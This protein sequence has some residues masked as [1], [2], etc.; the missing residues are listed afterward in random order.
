M[1]VG[2]REV[3]FLFLVYLVALFGGARDTTQ[4]LLDDK[5]VSVLELHS[6]TLLGSFGVS[7]A[8]IFP[9]N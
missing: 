8:D 6:Q 4:G 3:F 2:L 9:A 1:G 7:R 5:H